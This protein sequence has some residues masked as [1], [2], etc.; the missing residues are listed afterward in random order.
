[1][2]KNPSCTKNLS[3]GGQKT[4]QLLVRTLAHLRRAET[5]V[6]PG[7]EEGYVRSSEFT[8]TRTSIRPLP[9]GEYGLS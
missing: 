8:L 5:L 3:A 2:A 9:P 6:I 4:G 7:K 1:M